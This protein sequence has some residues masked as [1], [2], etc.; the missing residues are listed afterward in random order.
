MLSGARF[1]D[2]TPGVTSTPPVPTAELRPPNQPARQ[3]VPEARPR[4]GALAVALE[5]RRVGR[6]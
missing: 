1:V 4:L 6:N 3:T 2:L 5:P